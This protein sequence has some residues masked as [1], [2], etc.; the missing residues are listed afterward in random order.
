MQYVAFGVSA[1]MGLMFFVSS[2]SKVAGRGAFGD[3]VAALGDMRVLPAGLV[4][5][6]ATSVVAAESGVWMLLAVPVQA[7]AVVG[8]LLAAGLLI[9]FAVG[10]ALAVHRGTQAACRCFGYSAA[11][12]GVRHVVRNSVLAI[13][14]AVGLVGWTRSGPV[15]AGGLVVALAAGLL[16]GGMVAVLD[17]LIDLF[18]PASAQPGRVAF[19]SNRERQR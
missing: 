4:R 3:F 8:L 12:F 1:L 7:T 11:R 18:R 9:V 10:V 16:L 19:E 14:S 15:S 2:A 13:V 17:D 5:P 6:V